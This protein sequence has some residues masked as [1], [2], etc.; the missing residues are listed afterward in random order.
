MRKLANRSIIL[1]GALSLGLLALSV[2]STASVN[3]QA[4]AAGGR[5]GSGQALEIAP[6][7]INLTANPG[8]VIKT[9]ISLRDISNDKLRVTSQINDFEAAGEDGTPKILLD[10]GEVS[11]FS[12][13]TWVAPLP[14]LLL[15]PRQIRNLPVTITVPANAAPGGYYGVVRFTATPPELEGTGVSL[16]ASLGS[17]VL[18]R[19]NGA[20][21]EKI[22]IA[23]FSVSKNGKTGSMF[24]SAPIQFIQRLKNTGNVFD[25][26]SGQVTVDDMFGKRVGTVNV[27]LPPR[28]VLPAS[29]RKF[30]QPFDKSVIGDKRLFGKYTANLTIKY[31]STKQTITESITF[32]IIPY[33]LIGI[34]LAVLIGGF[35]ILRL[36]LNRYK[37]SILRGSR[38]GRRR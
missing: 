27:N 7:V 19:V 12:I 26:P 2:V 11:P 37:Q 4:P 30:E 24:E 5:P 33:K 6:P 38:G 8:Q 16:A 17:L 3:A 35:I 23:D 13:K 31:G 9:Q 32:Y 22:E 10:A 14:Q 25:Q 34:A 36:M 20:A 29:T 15:E 21:K 1:A 28:N 18:I